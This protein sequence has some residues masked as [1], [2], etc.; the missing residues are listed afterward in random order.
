M[1]ACPAFNSERRRESEKPTGNQREK[2]DGKE[3]KSLQQLRSKSRRAWSL[4]LK[5]EVK[6]GQRDSWPAEWPDVLPQ[7]LE[8]RETDWRNDAEHPEIGNY[9]FKLRIPV[10]TDRGRSGRFKIDLEISDEQRGNSVTSHQ[11]EWEVL[12]QAPDSI[13]PKWPESTDPR[14]V[15]K[16]PIGPQRNSQEILQHLRNFGSVAI[17]APRRFGKST[18]VEYLKQRNEDEGWI[19]PQAVVCTN[20]FR[21]G[22]GLD[23]E[24]LWNDVSTWLQAATGS[25]ITGS[26]HGALPAD[27]AFDHI[28]RA[29]KAKG[30]KG[31]TILFDEAQLF[32]PKRDGVALGDLLKDRLERHWSREDLPALSPVT[33]ALVGLPSL[34]PESGAFSL[35]KRGPRGEL[36]AIRGDFGILSLT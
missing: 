24:R 2:I 22:R 20:Y 26:P 31:I 19:V 18:L 6:S 29:V 34:R 23:Y 5:V 33:M 15:D 27:G 36:A 14:Y 8:V 35:A 30:K 16:S 17:T 21:M 7:K 13:T 25:S 32:F 1:P 4:R 3:R 12:N 28:R 9:S 10:R 11:F